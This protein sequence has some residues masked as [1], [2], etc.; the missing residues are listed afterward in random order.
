MMRYHAFIT[1]LGCL[2]ALVPASLLAQ[3]PTEP[4][5]LAGWNDDKLDGWE[6]NPAPTLT[7]DS[8]FVKEG[9]G[10][11]VFDATDVGGWKTNLLTV[12][13]DPPLDLS[14]FGFIQVDVFLPDTSIGV[15]PDNPAQKSGWN[16]VHLTV[17]GQNLGTRDLRAGW[18]RVSW[19]LQPDKVKEVSQMSF[20]TNNQ[21]PFAGPIYFDNLIARP[22][23]AQGLAPNDKLVIGWNTDEE[24]AKFSE[25]VPRKRVTT[26]DFVTEGE[27]ALEL[28]LSAFGAG[29]WHDNFVKAVDLPPVDLSQAESIKLDI[30]VPDESHPTDWWQLGIVLKGSGNAVGFPTYQLGTGW[31]TFEWFL[32]DDQKKLLADVSQIWFRTNSGQAWQGPIYVDALRASLPAGPPKVLLGDTNQDGKLTI[33]D[34]ILA[35]RAAVGALTTTPEIL[36]AVDLNKNGKVDIS[37]VIRLLQ[38]VVSGK[39]L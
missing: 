30:F 20:G 3:G 33:A 37:E 29:G 32:T 11:L 26:K 22:G 25:E 5:L 1:F 9:K 38:A 14:E 34:V 16:Q 6:G 17:A 18:N 39:P 13:L 12:S 2:V 10:A 23:K 24:V 35:L 4:K 36:S 27:G 21:F 28:D 15:N 19:S 7:T 31:H 8:Q